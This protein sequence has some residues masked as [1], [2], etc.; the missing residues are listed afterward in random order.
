MQAIGV[1]VELV[2]KELDCDVTIEFGVACEIDLAHPA[3][4]NSFKHAVMSNVEEV[5]I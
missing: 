4:A 1:P 3:N 5:A 2:G